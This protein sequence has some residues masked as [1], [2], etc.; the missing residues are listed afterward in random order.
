[1]AWGPWIRYARAH[2][3]KGC[4]SF[5]FKER[6]FRLEWCVFVALF[7][8]DN[9][10][11]S[12]MSD[13]LEGLVIISDDPS[14]SPLEGLDPMW[15]ERFDNGDVAFEAVFRATQG[16][17]PIY[18]RHSCGSCHADDGRGPGAVRKMVVVEGDGITPSSDQSELPLGHTVRN[19]LAGDATRGVE[20]P[21]I[22][23]LLV[24][25]RFGP[26]VFG[27]GYVEAILDEEIERVE[28]EQAM[29]TD[30]I[31]GRI[32]RVPFQSESNPDQPFHT[33]VR[34]DD[35]LIG[36]FGLKGRIG[37]VDDF[38][39][40]AYQGDMGVTSPLR[41]QELPAPEDVVDGLEGTDID[42]ET[43]NFVADY[44]RALRIPDR[45]PPSTEG[46]ELFERANC[47]VCHVPKLRTHSDYP[48][49]QIAGIDAEVYSDLL[50]HDM[51]TDAADGLVEFGA[52]EREWLTRPLIGLRHLRNYLHDGRAETIEAAI[53]L[54]RGEGSEANDSIDRFDA[55]SSEDQ[56]IL[57]AFVRDL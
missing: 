18:I 35:G 46:A 21:D 12:S 37:T 7:G 34:G 55:L 57:V 2:S 28:A 38:V 16:L 8:C 17:G 9:D 36:R 26:A 4:L 39:A 52:S 54:H 32:N 41:P 15:R 48:I 40:D 11:R 33:Y 27:R 30:G 20:P 1:V 42:A 29:R 23:N 53:A 50:V 47:A 51:G 43:V 25:T 24:T 10:D 31:S 3:M 45:V 14:D 44:I 5:I 19:Q 6:T 49:P 22:D 13:P 56:D